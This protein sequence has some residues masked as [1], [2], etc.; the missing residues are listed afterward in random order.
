MLDFFSIFFLH[1]V[2]LGSVIQALA[3]KF[4]YYRIKHENTY[5]ALDREYWL[6][7]I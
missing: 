7:D 4:I 2:Q 5:S 6:R 3:K 1:F